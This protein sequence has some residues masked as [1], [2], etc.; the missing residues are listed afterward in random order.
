MKRFLSL[1]ILALVAIASVVSCVKQEDIDNLQS[2]IDDIK[3]V[4]DLINRIQGIEVI[5]SYSDGS[6]ACTM[7]NN[8]FYFEVLPSG[9]SSRLA[10]AG[11]DIFKLKAVYTQTKAMPTFVNLPISSVRA[12]GDILVVTAS[13]SGLTITTEQSANAILTVTSGVSSISTGYYPLYFAASSLVVNATLSASTPFSASFTCNLSRTEGVTE[14]GIC[15]SEGNSLCNNIL[16]ADNIDS[17]GDYSVILTGL[18][19]NT[20]YYY[21]AYA[22]IGGIAPFSAVSSFVT[23]SLDGFVGTTGAYE[24]SAFSAKLSGTLSIASAPG[25]TYGVCYSKTNQAPTLSDGYKNADSIENG[26]FSV[27]VYGL[28]PSSDYYYRTFAK[29]G[30]SIAYGETKVFHTDASSDVVITG[31][32][33]NVTYSSARISGYLNLDKTN[34]SSLSYGFIFNGKAIITASNLDDDNRFSIDKTKLCDNTLYTYQAVV[35]ID[36]NMY[37]GEEL[38]FETPEIVVETSGAVDLGLSVKWSATNLGASSPEL[39]GSYFAW[40]ETTT[41][42]SYSWSNYKWCMGTEKTLTKYNTDPEYGIVDNIMTL[43]LEDDAAHVNLGGNWRMPTSSEFSELIN[44]CNWVWSKY[45]GQ[46]GCKII[47]KI[48]GYTEKAIFLPHYG[49]WSEYYSSTTGD[50]YTYVD[51]L[52]FHCNEEN[53]ENETNARVSV[54]RRA[55]GCPIRPVSD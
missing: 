22:V 26:S 6:V 4:E 55:D 37:Y 53:D 50:A 12:E 23:Q 16:R 29:S 5:P 24:I 32:Y 1:L 44:N 25:I 11:K 10:A 36:G 27:K 47:S 43:E 39:F 2:Q 28:A 30:T 13:A 51:V 8:E 46:P 15:Y 35:Q 17:N 48:S 33:S 9:A 14:Y 40:G 19:P 7:G 18:Q 21:K 34:Y 42:S 41:K 3:N 45:K 54:L 31:D 49:I 20:T 38:S 52:E